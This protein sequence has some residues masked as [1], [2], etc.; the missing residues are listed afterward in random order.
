MVRR[1]RIR[2]RISDIKKLK[3]KPYISSTKPLTRTTRLETRNAIK[4][5]FA[6]IPVFHHSNR[7]T[8]RL[9]TGWGEAPNLILLSDAGGLQGRLLS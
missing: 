8:L 6:N 4:T 5:H 9:S 3:P 1:R 2:L 7:T